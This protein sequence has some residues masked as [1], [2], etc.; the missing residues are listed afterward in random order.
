ML[1]CAEI[2]SCMN[3][4]FTI[5]HYANTADEIVSCV[6]GSEVVE[7]C[8]TNRWARIRFPD[9]SIAIVNDSEIVSN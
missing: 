6:P 9:G 2:V 1:S 5:R 4:L 3:P 7:S 8:P